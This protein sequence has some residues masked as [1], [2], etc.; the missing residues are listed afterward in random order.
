[1]PNGRSHLL[2]RLLNIG[3][4]YVGEWHLV[5]KKLGYTLY[6][7][8][9]SRNLLFAFVS[10]TEILYI[11]E[12]SESFKRMLY[13]YQKTNAAQT[14]DCTLNRLLSEL[15]QAGGIVEIY[16]LPDHGLLQVGDS[17]IDLASILEEN[18]IA[19]LKPK[20]NACTRE[21]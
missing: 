11:G 8:N 21:I 9:D 18:L 17:Y 7:E 3:F 1:M 12:I 2:T 19:V 13:G 10:E 6:S 15:L 14:P 4:R 5:R 20:W 16:A